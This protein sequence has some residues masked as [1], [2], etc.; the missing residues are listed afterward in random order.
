MTTKFLYRCVASY[1]SYFDSDYEISSSYVNGFEFRRYEVVKE[2]EKG[3]WISR[4]GSGWPASWVK[5]I[6]HK[7][8]RFVL[9]GSGKRFANE[10]K[11]A[12]LINLQHRT[13]SRK[14]IL[15][16]QLNDTLALI[17]YVDT[18]VEKQEKALAAG[19][20]P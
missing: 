4:N 18:A 12:A 3:F 9:K 10:T 7:E 8:C 14:R 6:N 16:Q 17:G 13:H 1:Y 5:N 20:Q 2:T 19:E 11:E 15:E